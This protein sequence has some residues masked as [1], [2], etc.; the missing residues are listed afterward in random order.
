MPVTS[1]G[2]LALLSCFA[3]LLCA[4]GCGEESPNEP[5]ANFPK[6]PGPGGPGGPGGGPAAASNPQL[7]A[8]M[9]KVGKGPQALQN[10]LGAA[11]K[12]AEPGW[13]TIQPRTKEYAGLAA[14]IGNYDPPRGDKE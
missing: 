3:M 9:E 14:E 7:K 13:D 12:Q 2:A 11:L 8:I 6:G 1:R 10:S 4:H 5:A